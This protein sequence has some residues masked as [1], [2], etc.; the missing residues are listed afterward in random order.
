MASSQMASPQM[1]SAQMTSTLSARHAR[2]LRW[3][4][5]GALV[6]ASALRMRYAGVH[7]DLARDMFIAWRTLHGGGVP[8]SGP[9]QI[10]RA[11]V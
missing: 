9:V 4:V 7:M 3:I 6:L 1:A 10:G 2:W 11:H 8:L 5:L